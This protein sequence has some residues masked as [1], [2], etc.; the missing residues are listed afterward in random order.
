MK[1]NLFE[2]VDLS[3]AEEVAALTHRY[4]V[5]C[6]IFVSTLLKISKVATPQ[7]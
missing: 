3:D 2:C 6:F 5:I 7:L 4:N 1:I